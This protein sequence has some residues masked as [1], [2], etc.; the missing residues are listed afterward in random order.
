MDPNNVPPPGASAPP[1]AASALPVLNSKV[2]NASCEGNAASLANLAAQDTRRTWFFRVGLAFNALAA[3]MIGVPIIGYV[4]STFLNKNPR[5]SWITLGPV[6][7]FPEGDTRMAK[8]RDPFVKP[9]DGETGNVPCWVRHIQGDKFQVFAINCT[10]LGCPVRWF[11][12]SRL[13][14]C[15]CHGGV[16]YEDGSHASGPPPRGLY[17]YQHRIENGKLVIYGGHLPNLADPA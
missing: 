4:F 6:E 9:W 14:M 11:N 5:S 10:H 13:F 7:M 16:F 15:P 12:E 1:P 3:T 2:A 17:Q 8:F